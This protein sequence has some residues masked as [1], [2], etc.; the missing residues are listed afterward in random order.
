MVGAVHRS[1]PNLLPSLFSNL[2]KYCTF[3]PSWKV[4][5]CVPIPKPGRTDMSIPKNLRPI[6]LLS[7]L[8]KTFE[9]ILVHRLSEAGHLTG[10]ISKEHMG[11]LHNRW[12][13]TP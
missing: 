13:S 2:L 9:K 5:K 1:S 8:G 10:G 12:Q 3:S 4:A 7:C 6:S 11:C